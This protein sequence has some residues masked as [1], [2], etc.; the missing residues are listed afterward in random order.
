MVREV[1]VGS[2]DVLM[3]RLST[4]KLAF[5]GQPP[6]FPVVHTTS[7]K[8]VIVLRIECDFS[9]N[10]GE[11]LLN[12][13]FQINEFWHALTPSC[14]LVFTTAFVMINIQIEN[15]NSVFMVISKE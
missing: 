11:G 12:R 10:I 9:Q 13:F 4:L 2:G 8:L 3:E 7:A 5:W 1:S 15:Q 14:S 6:Y